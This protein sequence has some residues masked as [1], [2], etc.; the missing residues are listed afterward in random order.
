MYHAI[1]NL[2]SR[3]IPFC[4]M[5]CHHL[6]HQPMGGEFKEFILNTKWVLMCILPKQSI[7]VRLIHGQY[8][9][10]LFTH[11][12]PSAK[13]EAQH[14]VPTH[15]VVNLH[16]HCHIRHIGKINDF[17]I[18]VH[19]KSRFAS[20]AQPSASLCLLKKLLLPIWIGFFFFA[21][22]STLSICY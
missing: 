7:I 1:I 6:L 2:I 21:K 13:E 14:F 5:A 8:F 22:C 10:T 17:D 4:T 11:K 3:S 15:T 12:R 20:Y 18:F 9:I 19:F 16:L